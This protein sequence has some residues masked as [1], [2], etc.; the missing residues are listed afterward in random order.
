[1]KKKLALAFLFMFSLAVVAP[2]FANTLPQEPV[3]TEK[4]A[5][6]K[7]KKSEAKKVEAAAPK[8]IHCNKKEACCDKGKKGACCEKEQKS[9][10][11][12]KAVSKK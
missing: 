4:K 8:E 5:V 11:K 9:T 7:A 6:K 1:M 12:K 3:K 2:S 10:A